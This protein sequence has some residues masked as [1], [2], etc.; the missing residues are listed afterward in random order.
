[1]NGLIFLSGWAGYPELFPGLAPALMEQGRF[2]TPFAPDCE[3][4]ILARLKAL[5]KDLDPAPV[6]LAWSTGAHLALKHRR[7][8]FPLFSRVILAAPFVRFID[9][10]SA[11]QVKAMLRSLRRD[12]GTTLADFYRLCARQDDPS[13]PAGNWPP[14]R[15]EHVPALAQ[16][17]Q[18]LLESQ[19]PV[20]ALPDPSRVGPNLVLVHG[21]Q[22]RVVPPKACREAAAL[23]AAEG[24]AP[25]V[26]TGGHGHLPPQTLLRS[27]LHESPYPPIL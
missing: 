18:F 27:L 12:P 15:P 20:P 25:R 5:A 16:G 23:L 11:V 4:A 3:E 19:A 8:L 26:L 9:H 2:L 21:D 1:M 14:L 6:L 24:H 10:V 17:L 13:R 7:A 22:D